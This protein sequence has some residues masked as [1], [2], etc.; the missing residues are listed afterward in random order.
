MS[1]I[2]QVK[3]SD[4]YIVDV[5]ALRGKS[6]YQSAIE[7]GLP[8]NITEQEFNTMLA[9]SGRKI[10]DY[11]SMDELLA[12]WG[13]GLWNIEDGNLISTKFAMIVADNTA[14]SKLNSQTRRPYLNISPE[15]TANTPVAGSGAIGQYNNVNKNNSA[16][17][18]QSLNINEINSCAIGRYN[19]VNGTENL[20]VGNSNITNGEQSVAFGLNNTAYSLQTVIGQ[21]ADTSTSEKGGFNSSTGKGSYFVVGNGSLR[22]NASLNQAERTYSNAFRV[23][24]DGK[25]YGLNAFVSSGADYA[26]YL[27]W[28]DGN[29][30]N[31]DRRGR[32]VTYSTTN[33]KSTIEEIE[34]L[35]ANTHEPIKI[36]VVTQEKMPTI[37]YATSYKDCI[38]VVSGSASII[39]NACSEEWNNKFLKDIY[40]EKIIQ[41]V[42]IPDD[43]DNDV[44]EMSLI[45]NKG[46]WQKQPVINPNY[47]CNKEYISREFRQEWDPVGML[48]VLVVEDDGTC[49]AGGYCKPS[50]DGKGTYSDG[51]GYKVIQRIDEHHIKIFVK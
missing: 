17:I 30:N 51:E 21:Y 29:P 9:S 37:R 19:T 15:G 16:A 5:P 31:E 12:D 8:S 44:Q 3:N 6:A 32:M 10:D 2:L 47:D 7:G 13:N 33:A 46:S 1:S 50:T 24:A 28:E 38:G 41:A 35:D 42:Y 11:N 14:D 36:K 4:G 20:A 22:W 27:E 49:W 39:G 26:E 48:G 25:C 43:I 34:I 40:G 45:K 18:G 23:G